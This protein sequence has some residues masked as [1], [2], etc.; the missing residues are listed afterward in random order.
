[1]SPLFA[2]FV[3]SYRKKRNAVTMSNVLKNAS[4]MDINRTV[5][6]GFFQ[7]MYNILIDATACPS[8]SL[9][10]LNN[11]LQNM[12]DMNIYHATNDTVAKEQHAILS[13]VTDMLFRGLVKK[14]NIC[15]SLDDAL[16][17]SKC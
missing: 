3:Q 10:A 14:G 15:N 9:E 16:I 4:S 1:M 6:F 11:L 2:M 8:T 7:A 12:L 13:A 5:E 17:D